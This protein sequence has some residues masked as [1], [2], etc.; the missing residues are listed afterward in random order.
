MVGVIDLLVLDASGNVHLVDY[1]TGLVP[2]M[3]FDS[4]KKLTFKYQMATYHRILSNLG[5]STVDTKIYIS[6]IKVNN[7]RQEGGVWKHESL[8][9]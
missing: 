7:L 1:K 6:P 2:Y 9:Y 4:A 5:L 8:S 3:D